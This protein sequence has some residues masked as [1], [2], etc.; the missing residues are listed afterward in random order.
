MTGLRV[1]FSA[2]SYG[3]MLIETNIAGQLILSHHTISRKHLTI[4]VD[5]VPEG[6]AHN[7]S[8]RSNIKIEDLATKIGTVINGQKIKGEVYDVQVE[9]Y[10]IMLGKCPDTFRY[11][12]PTYG[13][14]CWY[15]CALL[16]R[17]SG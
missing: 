10:E 2:A 15:K 13:C 9:E 6:H 7:L 11:L 17:Y 14:G 12:R 4:T 1:A 8:S 3:Q 5:H 16:T